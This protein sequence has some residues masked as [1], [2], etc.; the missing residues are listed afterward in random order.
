MTG[1]LLK[2]GNLDLGK[3]DDQEM[4]KGEEAWTRP[5]LHSLQK[6]SILPTPLSQA[7]SLH[8]CEK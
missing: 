4:M 1:I 8:S 6:K 5:F 2:R 7:P 3:K